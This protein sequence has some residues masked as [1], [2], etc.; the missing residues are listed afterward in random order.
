MRSRWR[1][2][3]LCCLFAVVAA[4]AKSEELEVR[5][6]V[7]AARPG[8]TIVVAITEPSSLDPA[9][10]SAFDSS[11]RLVNE[12]MC[13]RL[14]QLDPATGTPVGAI[15]ESWLVANGGRTFTIKLRKGTKFSNGAEVTSEDVAY[16]LTRVA[17]A[18]TASPVADQ[19]SHV[20]GYR[21][22]HGLD[23][24]DD[25]GDEIDTLRGISLIDNYSLQ[26]D[27]DEAD[28]EFYR[29]LAHPLATPLPKKLAKADPEAMAGEP[30]C[31]GPYVLDGAWGPKEPVIRL[32]P[33]R[34]YVA[35]NL[36]YTRGGAGYANVIE[37][38][39]Y[40]DA[41]AAFKAYTDGEADVAAVPD[42]AV[43]S[44]RQRG[45][46]YVRSDSPVLE[47]IGL[48][49]SVPPFTDPALRVALSL[50]IDRTRLV[51]D[52]WGNARTPATRYLPP[53]LAAA[54]GSAR[55]CGRV[56]PARAD[57]GQ[58]RELMTSAIEQY[59]REAQATPPAAGG[60]SPAPVSSA[61]ASPAPAPAASPPPAA[62]VTGGKLPITLSFNDEY[63]NEKL[64]RA[65]A[66]QWEAALPVDVRVVGTTWDAHLRT[67]TSPAGF[68]GAF[69][70][71]W[72]PEYPSAE[73]YIG[74]LFSTDNVGRENLSRLSLGPIDRS[75]EF[76]A[77]R[78]VDD[79]E[80]ADAYVGVEVAVCAL[81]PIIPIAFGSTHRVVRKAELASATK[82]FT[83][84]SWGEVTLRELYVR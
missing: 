56:A 50:A 2:V 45:G 71:S 12:T 51:R 3:A 70:M 74:K 16:S 37:F 8:G 34:S 65:V 1:S 66:A 24:E 18:E 17:M 11:A 36:G 46:D 63:A 9:L 55:Q 26:I 80:R 81:M 32:V 6:P 35:R 57:A 41:P 27:L 29:V 60:A 28:A 10:V 38:R 69:R 48:P 25:E 14:I 20:V 76:F 79:A 59:E 58:A 4:C 23:D 43:A 7:A 75:L 30:V 47:Y 19:L 73:Q 15:A 64:A 49:S 68:P 39:V 52:V 78:T 42:G 82:R 31:A 54:Y 67:A 72:A 53:T 21:S 33:N 5:R 22:M 77:R 44:A 62:R 40:R 83:D 84:R 13:D 61:A